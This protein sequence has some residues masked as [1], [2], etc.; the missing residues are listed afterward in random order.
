MARINIG[1]EYHL[2]VVVDK[3]EL[4][5]ALTDVR[6]AQLKLAREL[7]RIGFDVTEIR[8]T[9]ER[10]RG[11][12]RRLDKTIDREMKNIGNDLVDRVVDRYLSFKK[13]DGQRVGRT[14]TLET[15]LKDK[16]MNVFIESDKNHSVLGIMNR[17]YLT[18]KTP[19]KTSTPYY[20]YQHQTYSGPRYLRFFINQVTG[21]AEEVH[22][23]DSELI[24]DTIEKLVSAQLSEDKLS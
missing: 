15:S 9:A 5:E 12:K 3:T 19:T 22:A 10:F 21:F 7:K 13:L 6:A 16:S 14:G 24:V 2:S 17:A 20:I 23:K 11:R 8:K 18:G 4:E 1:E